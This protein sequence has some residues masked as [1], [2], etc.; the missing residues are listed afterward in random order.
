MWAS[1]FFPPLRLRWNV[2]NLFYILNVCLNCVIVQDVILRRN[3]YSILI[4]LSFLQNLTQTLCAYNWIAAHNCDSLLN[5]LFG[6]EFRFK[7]K[8]GTIQTLFDHLFVSFFVS[9]YPHSPPTVHLL[10]N[11]LHNKVFSHLHKQRA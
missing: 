3:H 6:F 1:K 2:E 4:F 7:I 11:T 10:T 8:T 9:N 5:N